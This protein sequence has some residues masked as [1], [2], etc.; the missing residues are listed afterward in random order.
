ME[1]KEIIKKIKEEIKNC[2]EIQKR[3][4][5]YLRH[6]HGN[7]PKEITCSY[8]GNSL[9]AASQLQSSTVYMAVTITALLN[10]YNEI[11]EKEYRHNIKTEL[12]IPYDSKM[13]DLKEKYQVQL[14]NV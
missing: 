6:N 8:S 1:T 11:R 4:K 10:F 13:N 14:V 2:T 5:G 7:L 9:L 3:E 12:K